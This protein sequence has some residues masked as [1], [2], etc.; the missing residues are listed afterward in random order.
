MNVKF[1]EARR[2]LQKLRFV[3]REGKDTNYSLYYEGTFILWTKLSQGEGDISGKIPHKIRSQ[4]KLCPQQF[5]K[6]LDCPFGY[7]DYIQK[8]KDKKLIPVSPD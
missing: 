4:M 6:A 5:Q 3:S 8:L 7:D 1:R 2:M